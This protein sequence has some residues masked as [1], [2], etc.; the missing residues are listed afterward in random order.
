MMI[1]F[2]SSTY[3]VMQDTYKLDEF[4]QSSE[5]TKI[6]NDVTSKKDFQRKSRGKLRRA[7]KRKAT[8]GSPR[9]LMESQLGWRNLRETEEEGFWECE[10]RNRWSLR[11]ANMQRTMVRVRETTINS[12]HA[13]HDTPAP[14]INPFF[15]MPLIN[16]TLFN[17]P[18]S[19]SC[20]SLQMCVHN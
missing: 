17:F 14:T 5:K 13:N 1:T 12:F 10:G 9:K 15:F 11:K 16:Y 2:I 4:S 7:R 6:K 3:Y 18:S 19:F 20:L 8:L